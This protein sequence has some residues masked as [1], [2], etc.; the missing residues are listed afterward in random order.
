M[1]KMHHALH[2]LMAIDKFVL[3]ICTRRT[4]K[5]MHI[6]NVHRCYV[7]KFR[8]L[9][10]FD[11]LFCSINISLFHPFVLHQR[12]STRPVLNHSYFH[13]TLKMWKCIQ[14]LSIVYLIRVGTVFLSSTITATI[15]NQTIICFS[16]T[17]GTW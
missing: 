6:L 1:H 11:K 8:F 17:D 16:D 4:W 5:H 7:A 13:K 12:Y 9:S 3:N 10:D 2:E 15:S 14:K